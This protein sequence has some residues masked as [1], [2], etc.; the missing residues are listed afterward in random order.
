MPADVGLGDPADDVLGRRA[1]DALGAQGSPPDRMSQPGPQGNDELERPGHAQDH[2]HPIAAEIA[3][4]PVTGVDQGL[5]GDQEA[6]ELGRIGRL[7]GMGSNAEVQERK[8]DRCQEAAP[9]RVGSIGGLGIA[10]PVV[11]GPPV[12]GR[13]IRD[14]IQPVADIGP[15]P[16]QVVGH[17]EHAAHSD[18]G[19][20]NGLRAIGLSQVIPLSSVTA[21]RGDAMVLGTSTVA[22]GSLRLT[23]GKKSATA[24]QC[25]RDLGEPVVASR[26]PGSLPGP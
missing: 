3:I 24:S 6:Q 9:P 18:D 12:S 2:A 20:R 4:G 14:C 17:G 8:F 7:H 1:I 13:D 22:Q 26:A 15:E 19:H 11:V 10:V 25:H 5:A 23:H 21:G 16:R